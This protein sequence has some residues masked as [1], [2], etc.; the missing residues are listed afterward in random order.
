MEKI[1][2]AKQQVPSANEDEEV[3]T[4]DT[5]ADQDT[6]G[7]VASLLGL[8][9][10]DDDYKED[11]DMPLVKYTSMD[12]LIGAH[13]AIPDVATIHNSHRVTKDAVEHNYL[14]ANNNTSDDKKLYTSASI[15]LKSVGEKDSNI[16]VAFTSKERRFLRSNKPLSSLLPMDF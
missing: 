6:S 4:P 9:D 3:P 5:T 11:V 13:I 14:H 16:R 8:H 10:S 7:R 15:T 2:S 12:E 1:N